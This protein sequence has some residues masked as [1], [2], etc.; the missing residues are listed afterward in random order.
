MK[1][2]F[3]LL[4]SLILLSN[5]AFAQPYLM[6]NADI[7][8]DNIVFNY[9]NDLW[10]VPINGG[11]AKRIT[12]GLGNENYPKFSPDG[13]KIAFT[14]NYDG[15]AD[16]YVMDTEGGVPKRLTYHPAANIVVDW[17][18]DGKFILFRS[19]REYPFRAQ[20][21][22][23]ISV[24]GG[25][26]EKLPLDRGGL[27]SLSPDGKS[28]A[29]NYNSRETATWKRHIGGDA[30]DIWLGSLEKLDYKPITDFIGTDNYPMWYKN[31]IYFNSDRED[32]TLNIYKYNI[33]TK[34][35]KRVTFYKDYDVKTPSL[36]NNKIIYSYGEELYVL[37]LLTEKSTKVNININS[38]KILVSPTIIKPEN[39][40]G[41]FT[42]SVDGSRLIID[43]R[44]EIINY[45]KD[46]EASYNL[47]LSSSTREKNPAV[48]PDG[49]YV[50]F[51]SD[52]TG[53]EEI[54]LTDINGKCEWK[55]LTKGGKGFREQLVFSPDGKYILFHD[56]FMKLNLVDVNTGKIIVVSQSDYDDSW[57][58]WGIRDYSF[59][60]DS[61][62]ICYAKL[63]RS[64]YQSIFIYSIEKQKEYRV[65]SSLTQDWSPSFSKDGKYL[66]FLSNRTFNPI[67][68][69]VDQN[70]IFMNMGKPYLVILKEGDVSPLS[71]NYKDTK[72]NRKDNV[73]ITTENFESRTIPIDIESGNL[74]RLEAV[75]DGFLYLKKNEPEFLKYQFVDDKNSAKN[76]DLYR[77]SLSKKSSN[78]VLTGVSQYH[79]S[80][81]GNTIAYKSGNVFGLTALDKAKMGDGKINLSSVTITIN[82]LE[83]FMQIFNEA[84][85]IERDWFYDPNMH[86][87]NWEKVGE[88]YRKFVPYCSTREDLNY[89]IGEMISELNAGHTYI[90]GGD[91]NT[92]NRVSCGLLGADIVLENGYPK[93]KHIIKTDVDDETAYSPLSEPGLGI[94]EGDFII[95]V[96][97]VPIEKNN[98]FYKYFIDKAN[99]VVE[100]TFNSKPTF[101]GAKTCLVKPIS[102]EVNLRYKE[103]IRNNCAY[104]TEKTN[105]TVGYVHIPGMMENGLIE[106]ARLFYPQYYKDGFI[107]DARYNTGGF[108]SKQI[109]DRLERRPYGFVKPREGGVLNAMERAFNGKLVL[110]INMDTGSDG[111]LFGEAW[112]H[113]KLGTV[114]GIR[115]WG[116]AVGIEPHQTLIDG[117]TCTP[118]QFGEFTAEGKWI[119]EGHGV[120]PDIVVFNM[121]GNVVKG[122]DEQLDKAIEVILKQIKESGNKTPDVP[123]YPDKSKPTLK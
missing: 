28:I 59:S 20:M 41:N 107:I 57:Y 52:K 21:L 34:E 123:K 87:V 51:L 113:H 79:I 63:D 1:K 32:G 33:D 102:N 19:S 82:R 55:Q 35:V 90:Y 95:A 118:P 77:Y 2:I 56:K 103:W 40:T 72:E 70:H 81:D 47:T 48:S 80:Y 86:G 31:Y 7:S 83:E 11:T 92:S 45:A 109:I 6:K 27:A 104:V 29:Y 111:E 43:I 26:P 23:K 37:D 10:L 78:Q 105:G 119:I 54:Y 88:K 93:I 61:K 4:I 60:P 89:L 98:N 121:P 65:T 117:A 108:T 16:V 99:K 13:K 25:M 36:G 8:E 9:E 122:I 75:N 84:W 50:A 115:T 120:D 110:L 100:L 112:K 38:D 64:L 91:L 69:F 106:F 74:F 46:E 24:N 73:I 49:K 15:G 42:P 30:Q 3:I 39:F 17:Y 76:L 85:R 67:M 94:K 53:E 18:P 116:G 68:D 12:N 62:W 66:Y 22:Y 5:M 58:N 44:G 14:A 101:E 96:N 71:L 114:I 97:G